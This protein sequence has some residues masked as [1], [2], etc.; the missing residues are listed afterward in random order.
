V[1]NRLRAL[2]RGPII[3]GLVV[4][5]LAS[6]GA[7][8]ALSQ[9][10][11][12]SSSSTT[13]I[14]ARMATI[15]S[16]V[17]ASGTIE[18]AQEANLDF[19]ASGRVK[20]VLVKAGDSVTKGKPLATLTRAALAADEAAAAATVT[21]AEDRVASDSSSSAT[22]QAADEAQL[23]AARSSLRSAK[24]TLADAV[25][26]ATI[27]GTVTS[28]DLTVGQQVSSGA[29]TTANNSSSS[30]DSDSQVVLQSSRSFIV[31]ATVDDT[32][33]SAVHKGQS[34]AIT[35]SGATLPVTGIVTSVGSVPTSSSGVVSF[36]IVAR[37]SG[38]PSGVY[39]GA[40][41]TLSIT[42]NK[43]VR[44]LEVPTLAVHYN[45]STASVQIDDGGGTVTRTITVGTTYGLETQVL[46]GL[47]VGDKV[48]V[49]PPTFTRGTTNGGSGGGGG[50][51]RGFGGG[52]FGNSG[53]GGG[54]GGGGGGFGGTGSGAGGFGSGTG[55]GGG[56]G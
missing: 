2:R 8:W 52:E 24:A 33:I 20:R 1:A 14:A 55:F 18:P 46:S 34:V 35:P 25:L 45:G 27:S 4:V 39:A 38:H 28:I 21:S 11:S 12:S 10:S 16:A 37:V 3:I 53:G 19:A 7:A 6:G 5:L 44:A 51:G 54:F 56:G 36:P 41:A 48:V 9:S 29:S 50:F 49:T 22:Q 23:T 26:R 31:D 17:S 13:L 32:Q 47:K 43:T 15:T 42:T 40:S 30:G